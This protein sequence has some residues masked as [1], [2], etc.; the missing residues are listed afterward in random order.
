[1]SHTEQ[2]IVVLVTGGRDNHNEKILWACLDGLHAGVLGPVEW[3]VQGGARGTDAM[4]DRWAE[5]NHVGRMTFRAEWHVH[6][7]SS[8]PIRNQQQVDWVAS[9]PKRVCV[10][11]AGGRGTADCVARSIKA[12]I[13]VIEIP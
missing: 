11:Q 8:G 1:M 9:K 10:A 7:P 2:G 3:V 13:R 12:G 5:L 4:A 6:G